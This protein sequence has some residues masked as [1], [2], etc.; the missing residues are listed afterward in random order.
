VFIAQ[1]PVGPNKLMKQIFQTL[2]T[3]LRILTSRRQT[4]W[5]YKHGATEKQIQIVVRGKLEPGIAGL[6]GRHAAHSATLPPLSVSA[7]C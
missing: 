6:R 3:L 2:T 7:L 1:V 5:L 4:S